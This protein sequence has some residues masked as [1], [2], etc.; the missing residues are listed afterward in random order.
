MDN[1]INLF[2]ML[3]AKKLGGGGD[4]GWLTA[5]NNGKYRSSEENK[6]G[7]RTVDVSVTISRAEDN[8]TNFSSVTLKKIP[9]DIIQETCATL[10]FTF[11]GQIASVPVFIRN[12]D[13]GGNFL[14]GIT[15]G[16]TTAVINGQF[17]WGEPGV[18]IQYAGMTVGGSLMDIT[19]MLQAGATDITFIRYYI[20]TR[21]YDYDA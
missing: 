21:T 13:A 15:D 7:Y 8:G 3:L 20:K 19:S 16:S 1:E 5:Y 9:I 6:D 2:D 18:T 10:I 12:G 14:G 4:M 11:S 17:T